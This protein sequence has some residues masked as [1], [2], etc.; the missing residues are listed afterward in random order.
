ME[1]YIENRIN[2]CN[3]CPYK[4]EGIC[5][6]CGCEIEEKVKNKGESCPHTPKMWGSIGEPKVYKQAPQIRIAG[7]VPKPDQQSNECIPC[8]NRH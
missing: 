6:L 2:I 5:I 7:Q 3:S 4:E 1:E 8:K